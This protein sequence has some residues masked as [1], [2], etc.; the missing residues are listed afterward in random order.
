M[1]IKINKTNRRALRAN[2]LIVC[3]LCVFG[4]RVT[5]DVLLLYIYLFALNVVLSQLNSF[6]SK[7][8]HLFA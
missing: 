5:F 4:L 6:I 1:K 3:N 8:F 7:Y 2:N